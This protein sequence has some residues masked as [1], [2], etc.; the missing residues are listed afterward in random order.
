[1]AFSSTTVLD[2]LPNKNAVSVREAAFATRAWIQ[3]PAEPFAK[4]SVAF[5]DQMLH[6]KNIVRF[7]DVETRPPV[8]DREVLI[9]TFF[10]T[11]TRWH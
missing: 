4:K 9:D 10:L 3:K 6:I 5:P 8:P 1:V 11:D 2:F 7:L